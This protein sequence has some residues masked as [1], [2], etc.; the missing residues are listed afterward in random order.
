MAP[1]DEV[2]TVHVPANAIYTQMKRAASA[3]H[4]RNNT[5]NSREYDEFG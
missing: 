1:A 3:Q 5:Q 2:G 4:P